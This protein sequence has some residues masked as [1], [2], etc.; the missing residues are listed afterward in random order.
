MHESLNGWLS[1]TCPFPGRG[2]PPNTQTEQ[3]W[4]RTAAVSKVSLVVVINI[5]VC[6]PKSPL[7]GAAT[8][9][10]APQNFPP[11]RAAPHS[12]NGRDRRFYLSSRGENGFLW[13]S[14]RKFAVCC[15]NCQILWDSGWALCVVK[16]QSVPRK[17]SCLWKKS[18]YF[19]IKWENFN[20]QKNEKKVGWEVNFLP[21][22][23]YVMHQRQQV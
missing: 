17:K 4:K 18:N 7:P 23:R 16:L 14:K 21:G 10:S 8:T 1:T 6:S 12:R 15:R 2:F 13:R 3:H 9:K 20:Q 22:L 11:Y 19:Q 5:V